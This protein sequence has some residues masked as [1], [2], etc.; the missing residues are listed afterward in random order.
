MTQKLQYHPDFM[1]P[2]G[3]TLKE[4]LEELGLSPPGFAVRLGWTLKH[5]R[6][7]LRGAAEITP[8]MAGQ[9]ETELASPAHFWLAYQKR[10]NNYLAAK[11][12]AETTWSHLVLEQGARRPL[13]RLLQR[14]FG[15]VPITVRD[16]LSALDVDQ[17][18]NLVDVALA[19]PTIEEFARRLPAQA[20][21]G[22]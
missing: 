16:D 22:R 4:K 12:L 17:I 18:E 1:Y 20:Q 3:E 9:L 5:L 7:V 21:V 13:L 14:R 11:A 10:Y 15:S 19:A 2:P 6:A 8:T